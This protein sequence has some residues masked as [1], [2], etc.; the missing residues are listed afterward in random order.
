MSTE[1]PRKKLIKT[2]TRCRPV[3]EAILSFDGLRKSMMSV[4]CGRHDLEEPGN[5]EIEKN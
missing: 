4:L 1:I 5:A 2:Y 3:D